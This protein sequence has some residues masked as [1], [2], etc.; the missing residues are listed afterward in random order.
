MERDEST[1]RF[2]CERCAFVYDPVLGLPEEGIAPG[3]AFAD[4]PDTWRCPDCQ[5]TKADFVA[6]D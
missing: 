3:T 5:V 2:L 1:Q 4:I 6:L